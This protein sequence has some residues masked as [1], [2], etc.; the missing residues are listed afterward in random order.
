M[1]LLINN[2]FM[3]I[4]GYSL[5]E[6]HTVVH[7]SRGRRGWYPGFHSLTQSPFRSPPSLY[8]PLVFHFLY[9][10][11]LHLFMITQYSL[12]EW[13]GPPSFYKTQYS[14]LFIMWFSI[15]L[16][17][18]LVFHFLYGLVLHL[19]TRHLIFHFLYSVALHIFIGTQY[20]TVF[21]VQCS[22]SL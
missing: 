21:T 19:F 4:Y 11:V 16:Q 8:D 18:T 13:F 6:V 20:S 10:L 5:P 2:L 14:T 15:S 22:I 12:S 7:R 17:I 3:V 9:G 1:P